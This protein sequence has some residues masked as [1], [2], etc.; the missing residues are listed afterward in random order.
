MLSAHSIS[1]KLALEFSRRSNGKTVLSRRRTGGL[2]HVG[3]SYW[4]GNV[5]LTQV[6]NPTAG[7]FAGDDISFQ[8]KVREGANVLLSQPGAT[9]IHTM[10]SNKKASIN[11]RFEVSHDASLDLYPDLSISQRE[12]SLIQ[13]T[14]LHLAS[15][16][17][18]CYL[19]IIAPGRVAHGEAL[20]WNLLSNYT[21]IYLEGALLVRERMHLGPD[22]K[23]RLM[24]RQGKPLYVATFWIR[25][26][27]V[28]QW[29]ERFLFDSLVKGSFT[30]LDE[31]FACLRLASESSVKIRNAV[32]NIREQLHL[33]D[34]LFGNSNA[35]Y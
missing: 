23:W 27:D 10:D 32:S 20:E 29:R 6:V 25:H 4:N 8:I 13:K 12:S 21:D 11:Q 24:T 7:F 30:I 15:S 5:L 28:A 31:G 17:K 1:S 35:L 9:R 19:E 18:C 34:P 2:A 26:L 16:A 22:D 14:E 33:Y 3:K